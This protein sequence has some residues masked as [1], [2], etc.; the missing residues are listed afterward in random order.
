MKHITI[1]IVALLISCLNNDKV[2][3]QNYI[4]D[5]YQTIYQAEM[6]YSTEDYQKAF[7]L[8]QA[9]F[10]SC[11][12]VNTPMYYEISKFAETCAILGKTELAVDFLKKDFATGSQL[13]HKLKNSN[14]DNLFESS[15]GK[16]LIKNYDSLRQEYLSSINLDLRQEIAEMQRNDQKYRAQPGFMESD[17]MKQKQEEI[18]NYNTKRLIEIFDEYGYPNENVI[19]CFNIDKTPVS[20]NGILLHTSDSIRINYFI[21]IIKEYIENGECSPSVL[22]PI[23][24]QYYL[25]NGEP[26]INGTYTKPDGSYS[27]MID[28]LDKVDENRISIG[29][30]PLWL[31]EKRDNLIKEKYGY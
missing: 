13:E 7:E 21:P 4:E 16:E 6:A 14:F 22:G 20:I 19:G 2:S 5:Y 18:D 28:D 12:P 17:E 31:Q 10:E 25:Y 29:L 8:Y 15:I 11:E 1:T 24:D 9:A 3:G 30:P 23:I 26:Q 27:N